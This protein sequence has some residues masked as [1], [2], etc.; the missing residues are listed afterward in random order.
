MKTMRLMW[1]LPGL[2]LTVCL[3]LTGVGSSRA[4]VST[5][6]PT[7]TIQATAPYATWSGTPGVF[8]VVRQGNPAPALDVYYQISGTA[9]NGVDYQPI[10]D[11]ASI[12]SGVYSNDIVI[13]PI[14]RSQLVTKTVTLTL[15]NAPV[16]EPASPGTPINYLIN[17]P[18]S[19]TVWIEPGGKTNLP[20]VVNITCPTNGAVFYTPLNLPIVACAYAPDGVV[21]Q[22]EF[23]TNGVSLGVVT[24]SPRVLP[25]IVGP[26]PPFPPMPPYQPFVLVW[27][28]VPA[29]T[30]VLLTAK[31]TDNDGA[32][33]LSAPV[34]ITVHPGP[35]PTPT[36]LPPVVRITSPA[37]GA[38]FRTPVNIPI[39]AYARDPNGYVTGVEFFAGS[40][41]LGPGH[42]VTAVPPPLPPG[43]VQPPIIIVEPTN[44]WEFVW[45]N[46]PQG[47]YALTAVATD[48]RG[49]S[50]VSDAVN[51]TILPPVTPPPNPSPIVN[52]SALDPIAIAGTN[53]WPWLGL[54]GATPAWTNWTATT[55]V[56]A[57]FT[58]CG[59]KDAIFAVR[60]FGDTNDDLAV[61]Y[62]IGGTATNGVD[63]VTL[64]GVVTI[65]AGS[66]AALITVIPIDNVPPDITR[67]VILTLTP[68]TNTPPAYVIG[69]PA[70]AAAIILDSLNPPPVSGVLPDRTFHVNAAG[71]NGAWF[72][73]EYSPDL[74]GWT[75]ICSSTNQ[76]FRG[77]LD[78]VDPDAPSNQIRFYRAVPEANPPAE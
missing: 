37:D 55:S 19:A 50:A 29:G 63:Y 5:Q 1:P 57:Y 65:P 45:T 74:L 10:S 40:T 12:P 38:V 46:P 13:T 28:N 25:A 9:S 14:N 8:T 73:I 56:C 75:P 36:N 64:P 43:P 66:A 2:S 68:S 35:A 33:T 60:R 32:S 59:P 61:T 3:L 17:S 6:I 48:N 24:N 72:H 78:F 15:T 70:K 34:S 62:G 18:S 52:I 22:V 23:F 44:Y 41:D 20:P 69:C 30:N 77:G 11:Y 71:P 39:Y 47:T 26:V 53:C 4:Q 58:N 7:V 76:V 54:V 21:T 27:S 16:L 51:V 49:L 42:P 31:A 67:T